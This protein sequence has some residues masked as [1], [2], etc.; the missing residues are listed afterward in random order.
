MRQLVLPKR[1]KKNLRDFLKKHPELKIVFSKALNI[2]QAD[3]KDSRLKLHKLTGKL[4]GCFSIS[5]AYEYRL[6]LYFEKEFIFL[7]AIGTHDEV[8]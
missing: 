1:F 3:P 8:Y 5:I 7:L 6:V 4:A 2:L